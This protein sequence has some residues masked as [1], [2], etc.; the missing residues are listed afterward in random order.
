[1]AALL[2]DVAKLPKP[3]AHLQLGDSTERGLP[4][5]DVLA[6]RWLGRLP[7]PAYTV[8]GNHDIMRNRRRAMAWAKEYGYKSHNYVIDLPFLRIVAV[9]PDRDHPKERGG[10]LSKTTIAWLDQRLKHAEGRDCWVACHWPLYKT[11]MGDSRKVYTSAMQSFYAKPNAQIRAVLARHPNAK[12]WL[13][14]HTH[15]PLNA[16]G[17]I[18]RAKLPGDRSIV[19]INC[20]AIVGVGKTR[21]PEDPV[22]S[23]YVTQLPGKLEVRFRDHR[24]RAWK[25]V[26]R[27]DRVQTIRV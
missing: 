7:G 9:S 12:A 19:H 6:L 10:M 23:L 26:F 15:S 4:E 20:S 5:E 16:P 2:D 3:A 25:P 21:D 14:G 18:T 22:C 17:L 11:V 1:M 8:L 24:A 27:G 13:S